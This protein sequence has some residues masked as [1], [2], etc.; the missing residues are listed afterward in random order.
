MPEPEKKKNWFARHK[1]LTVILAIIVVIAIAGSNGSSDKSSTS[2]SSNAEQKTAET[3]LTYQEVDITKF[4][5]AFDTNQLSA[6]NQYKGKGVQ[7]KG[8]IANISEDIT[9]NPFIMVRPSSVGN[10]YTGTSIQCFFKNKEDLLNVANDQIVMVKGKV[11][12]QSL[13]II[14]IKDCQ[15]VE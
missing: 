1:V 15:I 10:L 3:E 9:G 11:N 6:E 7:L 2:N 4:I 5:E 12:E 14:M 13:G 8:K